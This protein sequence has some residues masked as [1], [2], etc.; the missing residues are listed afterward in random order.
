MHNK[1]LKNVPDTNNVVSTGLAYVRRL[2]GSCASLVPE[3]L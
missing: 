3:D 1:P 2:A